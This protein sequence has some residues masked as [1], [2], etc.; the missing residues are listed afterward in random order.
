MGKK[1]SKASKQKQ[2]KAKAATQKRRQNAKF[3]IPISKDGVMAETKSK[4]N[5][6]SKNIPQ[7]LRKKMRGS[8]PF[9]SNAKQKSGED[10]DFEDE[11]RSLQE[12]Q[13]NAQK[14][15][16][17]SKTQAITMAPA[18]L[19]INQKPTT[20]QLVSDAASHLGNMNELGQ[21]SM[22][23]STG[24]GGSNLLQVLAA[25]KRQEDYLAQQEAA[26]PR[27]LGEGNNFWALRDDDSD[28][29][30][31]KQVPSFN[32]AAPSFALPMTNTNTSIGF[33]SS[34]VVDDDPDL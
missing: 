20:E 31:A 23:T 11:Y 26:K 3:N 13:Y 32:F 4:H 34:V 33:N 21:T 28:E 18:T 24:L 15:K 27:D 10:K 2:A 8:K 12:R 9:G 29:E 16:G 25:Q 5:K 6:D 22:S 30:G 14:K 17:K 7:K 1:K 19:Q